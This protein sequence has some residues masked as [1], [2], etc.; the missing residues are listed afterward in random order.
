MTRPGIVAFSLMLTLLIHGR[1]NAVETS[2]ETSTVVKGN[3][4]SVSNGFTAGNHPVGSHFHSS[5]LSDLPNGNPPINVVGAAEVGGFFDE[6]EIRGVSEFD[7]QSPVLQAT[8]SFEVLDLFEEGLVFEERGVDGLFNQ[9]AFEG[10]IDVV[11]FEADN[12]E[13]LSDYE[14]APISDT[15]IISVD[16]T[17]SVVGGDQFSADVTSLYNDLASRGEDLG[18]RFQMRE[19]NADA[20]AITFSNVEL[21]LQLQT[22]PEPTCNWAFLLLGLL[23]LFRTRR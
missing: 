1:I 13:S 20:G 6:E 14:I 15:P 5:N 21:Q 4:F 7:V 17:S 12:I 22:V 2:M 19:P 18:I 10:I 9:G 23:P 8:L 16:V 3:T 11:A